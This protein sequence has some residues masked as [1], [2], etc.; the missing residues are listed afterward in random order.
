LNQALT[1]VDG[2]RTL[3]APFKNDVQAITAT[4]MG[5]DGGVTT[6]TVTIGGSLDDLPPELL[7]MTDSLAVYVI[8]P[9]RDMTR[10]RW[11]V[12][13]Q[14]SDGFA[15]FAQNVLDSTIDRPEAGNLILS[16]VDVKSNVAAQQGFANLIMVFIYG[17]IA[18]LTLIGLTNVISTISTNIRLR[19]REFAVLVS[20][21]MTQ[22]GVQRMIN[23]ESL[24]CG[25]RSLFFGLVIGIG[26]S[27]LI[28][29][30]ITDFAAYPYEFPLI[31][32]IASILGVFAVTFITQRI[33]AA[34]VRR[35]N[36]IEAIRGSE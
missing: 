25:L 6:E 27:Y 20:M 3:F 12:D 21:G 13:V 34:K 24:L 17:F 16:A 19:K 18:M 31:P 1:R 4:Q 7:W 29:S 23:Y 9:G 33:S 2:K 11:F 5:A 15:D 32:V 22:S 8:T 26:L 35:G 28:Y 14:D 10:I 30:K 36:V